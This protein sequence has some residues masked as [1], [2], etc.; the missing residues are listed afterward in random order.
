MAELLTSN[1]LDL[2]RGYHGDKKYPWEKG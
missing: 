1:S 2:K